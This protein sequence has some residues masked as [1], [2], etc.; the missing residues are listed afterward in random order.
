M[1]QQHTVESNHTKGVSWSQ[2]KNE[3]DL[4]WL[5]DGGKTIH[6]CYCNM[7]QH[8]RGWQY[9][10]INAESH[11][12]RDLQYNAWLKGISFSFIIMSCSYNIM[13][14][15]HNVIF[16]NNTFFSSFSV[17]CISLFCSLGFPMHPMITYTVLCHHKFHTYLQKHV[18]TTQI[19]PIQCI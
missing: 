13:S 5:W 12:S 2:M 18:S 11:T 8:S 17:A 9:I 6:E 15:Q 19:Q 7:V 10:H 1:I 4:H 14:S 3:Y 16:P